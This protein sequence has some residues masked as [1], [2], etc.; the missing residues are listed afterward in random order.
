MELFPFSSPPSLP[1]PLLPLSLPRSFASLLPFYFFPLCPLLSSSSLPP[2][3]LRSLGSAAS[4]GGARLTNGFWYTFWLENYTLRDS[5][6]QKFCDNQ[7]TKFCKTRDLV[8][9]T[10]SLPCLQD[11]SVWCFSVIK[12]EAVYGFEPTT[13][14]LVSHTVPFTISLSACTQVS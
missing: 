12:E 3:D 1:L 13:R 8:L 6:L 4:S 14:L 5:E 11:I 2:M 9:V 10:W 7:I